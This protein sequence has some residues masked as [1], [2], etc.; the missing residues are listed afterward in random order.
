M[1]IRM[2]RVS[3]KPDIVSTKVAREIREAVDDN[4]AER[5][6]DMRALSIEL[7]QRKVQLI[8]NC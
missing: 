4:G 8:K 2:R 5:I 7:D 1:K 3:T 6:T